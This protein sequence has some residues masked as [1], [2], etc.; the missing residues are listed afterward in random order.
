MIVSVIGSAGSG[1]TMLSA[2]LALLASRKKKN[3]ILVS[4]SSSAPSS[5]E[6]SEKS[7]QKSLGALLEQPAMKEDDIV[8]SLFSLT[9]RIGMLSYLPGEL[10]ESYP[11]VTKSAALTFFT[12][13]RHI[14]DVVI[15]D[16]T[17]ERQSVLEAEAL[18]VSDRVIFIQDVS[19]KGVSA[20]L[21]M[22]QRLKLHP[23]LE[24][25]TDFV[26]TERNEFQ[27]ASDLSFFFVK[28]TKVLPFAPELFEQ[29]VSMRLFQPL[30]T[31]SSRRTQEAI[32]L[33]L[34]PDLR[35][36][37]DREQKGETE[38]SPAE[39]VENEKKKRSAS[40]FGFQLSRDRGSKKT[41]RRRDKKRGEF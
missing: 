36:E 18:R 41:I 17:A 21:S 7:P 14:A 39:T 38:D 13:L 9:D 27:T 4:C 19:K 23:E 1:K 22:K 10:S 25:I 5:A 40:L 26:V 8:S 33:L 16:H 6:L 2:K 15:V 37:E 11:E 32:R 35:G 12:Y 20:L 3:V 24:G 30:S 31:K 34:P 29:S 28:G